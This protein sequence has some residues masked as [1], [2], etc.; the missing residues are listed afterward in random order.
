MSK[1]LQTQHLENSLYKNT[2]RGAQ[3]NF[4]ARYNAHQTEADLESYGWFDPEEEK[5]LLTTKFFEDTSQTI[6]NSNDSPDIGFTYSINPYRGCEHGCIY[7]YARPTH[8]Y[9]NLSPGLDFESKIFVKYSAPELLRKK[10]LT[11][12]W[13]GETI[14]FSGI[15][16]C[17]QPAERKFQLTRSCLQVLLEF[18]NPVAM[19]T[20]NQLICRDID[21]L[22]Q[23]AEYNGAVVYLSVTS[24]NPEV[25]RI[26]EPRTSLPHARLKAI[27]ELAKAGIPVGVN[28]APVI[29]GLTDHEM[30]SILKAA[31]EAGAK[32]A[33]YTPV[34]LPSTVAPLFEEWLNVHHPD[35]KNKIITAIRSMRDGKLNDPN[36][37]SRMQGTGPRADLLSETFHLFSKKY[38]F[39]NKFFSLSNE[40]FRKVTDQMSFDF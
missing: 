2:G 22:K 3:S 24:L 39:N 9:L 30:P 1:K 15:T 38:N 26:L 20:K 36:F 13:V 34:R 17:Y 16:D 21:I 32:Y 28:V 31:A 29:P 7:C 35:R 27:E 23:M 11:K 14:F 19:I 12:S 6:V 10:L 25:T 8:E 5:S 40:S 18:R 33:G 37:G 4:T